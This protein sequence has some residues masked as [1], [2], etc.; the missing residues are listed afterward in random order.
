VSG[1]P[2]DPQRQLGLFQPAPAPDSD[3]RL[4]AT[5]AAADLD[6]MTPIEALTLLAALKKEARE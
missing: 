1:T 3:S 5:L 6:R 2:N 4:R